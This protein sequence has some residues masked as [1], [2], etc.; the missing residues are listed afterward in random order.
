MSDYEKNIVVDDL[1]M[2]G[3]WG[4]IVGWDMMF[5]LWTPHVRYRQAGP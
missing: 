1:A 4:A 5:R 3:N 2:G